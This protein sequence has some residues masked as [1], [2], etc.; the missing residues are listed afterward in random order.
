[1][2]LDF[3]EILESVVLLLTVEDDLGELLQLLETSLASLD[4]NLRMVV[5]KVGV[6]ISMLPSTSLHTFCCVFNCFHSAVQ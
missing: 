5:E 4:S 1:M 2:D 3:L 6:P